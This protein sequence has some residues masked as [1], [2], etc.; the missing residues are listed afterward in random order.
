[1][2]ELIGIEVRSGALGRAAVERHRGNGRAGGQHGAG[3]GHA[4]NETRKQ[5]TAP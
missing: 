3:K 2:S 1:M 5:D 4:G